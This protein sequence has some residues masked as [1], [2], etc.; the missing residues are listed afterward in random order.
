MHARHLV[1]VRIPTKVEME[2]CALSL[3]LP[4]S[5]SLSLSARS[6]LLKVCKCVAPCI[7]ARLPCDLHIWIKRF[8][9][10]AAI[11]GLGTEL[12]R[13]LL[14]FDRW[15][16]RGFVLLLCQQA[17]ECDDVIKREHTSAE[18][19]SQQATTP[20]GRWECVPPAPPFS[21]GRS[22]S[23]VSSS[24]RFSARRGFPDFQTHQSQRFQNNPRHE[25][26]RRPTVRPGQTPASQAP[27]PS[28]L[29]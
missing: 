1:R 9:T 12:Y 7:L 21:E 10:A 18:T 24:S 27:A 4:L 6:F 19:E 26:A 29:R 8:G 22:K 16:K 25:A 20:R 15:H 3:S 2:C 14:V 23:S 11:R 28:P 13:V 5:L 17:F